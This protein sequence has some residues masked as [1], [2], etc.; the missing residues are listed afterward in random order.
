VAKVALLVGVSQYR[1]RFDPL[2]GTQKDIEAMRRVL[3]APQMGG[4]DQV[5]LLP[6]L[7]RQQMEGAIERWFRNRERD[8]LV[9]LYFAGHSIKDRNGRLYLG[10]CQMEVDAS[11]QLIRTSA[12]EARVVQQLMD[13]SRS[14][15]QVLILDS[16]FSGAIEPGMSRGTNRGAPQE[17]DVAAALGGE[18]RAI[19]T[20]ASATQHAYETERGGTYTRFLV[21]GIET[22]AADRDEDGGITVDELHQYACEKLREVSPAIAPKIYA[23]ETGYRIIVTSAPLGDPKV[24]Y[25][26]E[27]DRVA[28]EAQGKLSPLVLKGLEERQ[29]RWGLSLDIAEEIRND[30]LRPYQELDE[31]LKKYEHEFNKAVQAENPLI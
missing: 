25:R 14:Q 9:L 16:C 30:V 12:V 7:D 24:R 26:K 2:P 15:R 29:R 17:V 8:D 19:L 5:E 27:V 3:A 10:T 4:F 13:D 31:K 22:G 6:D 1:S 11:D 20:A 23:V 18:G 21:E 28:K